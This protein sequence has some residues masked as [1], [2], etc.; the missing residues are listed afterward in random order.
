[1]NFPRHGHWPFTF[2]SYIG[3][4]AEE[5]ERTVVCSSA[6]NN[7]IECPSLREC[8]SGCRWNSRPAFRIGFPNGLAHG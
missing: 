2:M 5:P 6:G 4:W 1:V 8:G 3:R 7:K